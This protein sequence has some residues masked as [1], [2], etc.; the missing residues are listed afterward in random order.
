MDLGRT[1]LAVDD[2]QEVLDFLEKKLSDQNYHVLRAV[3][4]KEAIEQAK[5][6][7]PNLIIM[8]IVLPDMEGSEAV[9]VLAESPQTQK[10]PV[11][12][13]SGILSKDDMTDLELNVGGRLYK[14]LSKPLAFEDL[15]KEIKKMIG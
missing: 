6:N 2:E 13:L 10:I 9:R 15:L 12:F 7:L 11:I 4:A 3:T 8:D 1:I 5:E 14:A